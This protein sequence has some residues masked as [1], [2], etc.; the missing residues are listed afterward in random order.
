AA[1]Q[2]QAAG[3]SP[4]RQSTPQPAAGSPP[5]EGGSDAPAPPPTPPVTQPKPTHPHAALAGLKPRQPDPNRSQR[6]S[7][8]QI[9]ESLRR[10]IAYLESQFSKTRLKDADQWDPETFAGLNALA[11]Y[12]LLHAGQ[13]V[14][15]PHLG[16]QSERVQA[17]L[18]RL[19]EYP[20]NG[21]RATYSRSLRISALSVY[22]RP[23]DRAAMEA[24]LQ[25]LLRASRGG[26]YTYEM[27]PPQRSRDQNVWDNSNSQYGAL[28]VWAAAD[29]GLRVPASFWNDVEQHWTSTQTHSGGWGYGPGATSATLSM[30]SAGI[31]MLF[32][33]RDQL[34]IEAGTSQAYLPLSKAIS[35]ALEWLDEG[36]NA[37]NIAAHPG[38]T[39][40]GLERAGLASGYK[41]FGS[42]D[43]YLELAQRLVRE[44][45]QD[46]GW[47]GTDGRIAETSFALL[48]LARGRYPVFITKL[49]FDGNWNNRPRDIA[50]L[51]RF[52]SQQFERTL[53]FQ[54]ADIQRNWWEWSDSPS[55]FIT[56]DRPPRFTDADVQKIRDFAQAGGIV[57]THTERNSEEVNRFFAD[58]AGRAFP[59][60]PLAPLPE[61]HEIYSVVFAVE[62]PKPPLM[63]VSNGSRLLM[64]HSPTELSRHWQPFPT[65]TQ[66]VHSELAINIAAYAA[67]RRELRNRLASLYVPQPQEQPAGT[68]P[69]ARLKFDGN[70]DPEPAA[71][72]R[73]ARIF[74]HQTGIALRLE[75][76][77]IS[78]LRY[79]MTPIAH[80]TGLGDF[81][82]TT[83]QIDALRVFV[84]RGGVLLIDATAGKR[85]FADAV[86]QNLLPRMFPEASLIPLAGDEPLLSGRLP[87]S[88]DLREPLLRAGTTRPS[89]ARQIQSLRA[90][91][92]RI[93][94]S[95]LDLTTA[96]LGSNTIGIEGY[97]PEYAQRFVHN[98]VL[99]TIAQIA[100]Q[101]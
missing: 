85:D 48:F 22:K 76:T 71:W 14:G 95:R 68:V 67:G 96:L 66:R 15:D 7:D 45:R 39:Y 20:M 58:L 30:T 55:L 56:T 52:A 60:Y 101:L 37:V 31:T 4:G 100:R 35:R 2:P 70:W 1:L 44:Q 16:P 84:V 91:A 82:P 10:G 33:A 26:A 34:A 24:D 3:I 80:L 81:S 29:A 43:W 64:V 41:Y 40:Y 79:E 72:P 49:R 21:N 77:D 63:G 12:A 75:P 88:Y 99:W 94:Y 27:P 54:V 89:T 36:D 59:E 13:S 74:E 17:L 8:E 50:V 97:S 11:I 6:L 86:E 42:H 38:Y 93:F 53:N 28:G 47:D 51:T 92:G 73:M 18:D 69:L 61:D 62:S 87:G 78:D 25:W 23:Q 90:G 98:L 32:V 9:G 83:A 57:F 5:S 19:K 65:R 46:G